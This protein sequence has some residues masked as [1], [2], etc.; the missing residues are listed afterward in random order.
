MCPHAVQH[1]LSMRIKILI[2]D[3]VDD[4]HRPEPAAAQPRT[5]AD[6]T[7]Q[8]RQAAY[9]PLEGLGPEF[10]GLD[11]DPPAEPD[12]PYL[13]TFE[14]FAHRPVPTTRSRRPRR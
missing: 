11:L 9:R 4:L 5:R 7:A 1:P 12:E 2:E 8:G 6:R 3:E 13:F 10:D 14:D